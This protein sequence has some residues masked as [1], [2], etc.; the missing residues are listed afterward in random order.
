M[1]CR[2][3]FIFTAGSKLEAKN[4]NNQWFPAAVAETDWNKGEVLVHFDKWSFRY[5]EWISMDSPRLRYLFS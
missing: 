3:D 4:F 1:P 5:D 2:T